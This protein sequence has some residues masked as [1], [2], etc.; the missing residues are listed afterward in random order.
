MIRYKEKIRAYFLV[1]QFFCV[2]LP[3]NLH[4]GVIGCA[5]SLNKKKVLTIK[6]DKPMN[7]SVLFIRTNLRHIGKAF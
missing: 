6:I 5:D 3:K 7:H 1:F 2:S 4:A